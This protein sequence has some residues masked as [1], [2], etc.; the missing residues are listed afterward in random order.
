MTG[1]CVIVLVHHLMYAIQIFLWSLLFV[2]PGIIATFRY[3]QAFYLRVDHPEWTSAQ[4]LA[5][6]S[7][8]MKGNKL[9]YFGV[10]LSFIGWYI[11]A[12]IPGVLAGH[13]ISSDVMYI[14]ATVVL[15]IPMLFVDLYMM[16]T[17][18]VFYEILTGNL[19]VQERSPFEQMDSQEF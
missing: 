13:F 7:K 16:L 12:S 18:T 4:C 17:Q 5:A 1:N 9:K 3:S 6:S 2:I 8:L 10:G 14:V 11:L 19:V 15:S